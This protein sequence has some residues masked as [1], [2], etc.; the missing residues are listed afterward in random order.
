MIWTSRKS[1]Y[2]WS[3][4]KSI[5]N[6]IRKASDESN[7]ISDSNNKAKNFMAVFKNNSSGNK[8]AKF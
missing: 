8:L 7:K 3:I 5:I 6:G 2:K 1:T 4:I